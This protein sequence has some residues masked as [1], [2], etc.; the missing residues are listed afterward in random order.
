LVTTAGPCGFAAGRAAKGALG[1]F[2]F[3]DY[4]SGTPFNRTNRPNEFSARAAGGV[5]FDT[6]ELVVTGAVTATK[7]YL[8]TDNSSWL[9][10]DGTNL[11]FI[12]TVPPGFTNALTTNTP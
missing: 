8:R 1:S 12:S 10:S 11:F 6:P 7:Y 3:A 2:V 9:Y 5:Y 4:S